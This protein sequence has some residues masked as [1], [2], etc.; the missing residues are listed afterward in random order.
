MSKTG[1]A[2]GCMLIDSNIQFADL[3]A[4]EREY[5]DAEDA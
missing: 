5:S 3:V 2:N 1:K 4:Y